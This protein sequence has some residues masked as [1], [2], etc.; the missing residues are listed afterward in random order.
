MRNETENGK[1]KQ[2]FHQ[3]TPSP[4]SSFPASCLV[5]SQITTT[6]TN[7][8]VYACF[9]RV[10]ALSMLPG[11]SVLTLPISQPAHRT[12]A[13]VDLGKLGIPQCISTPSSEVTIAQRR[14]W[15]R[16]ALIKPSTKSSS[17][18]PNFCKASFFLSPPLG[19]LSFQM[20]EGLKCHCLCIYSL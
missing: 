16:R 11:P 12:G 3:S 9:L 7:T 10:L 2:A 19:T 15:P 8:P 14:R 18:T 5:C 4:P 17:Q 1:H 6:T 20:S 13:R